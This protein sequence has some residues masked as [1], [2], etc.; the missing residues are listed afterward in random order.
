MQTF[1]TMRNL[2]TFLQCITFLFLFSACQDRV[3]NS[4]P[5]I[6]FCI[7]DDQSWLHTGAMGDPVVK[8]PAFDFIA[9]EGI[10]FTN[11]FCDAPSCGPSRSAI[12]TGQHI[13]RLEE[14]GNIH[15]TLPDKFPTYTDLLENEGYA[16]GSYGKPW[17]PGKFE[18]P[19]NPAGKVFKSFKEFF[20]AKPKDQPFCFWLGSYDAHRAYKL[21]S[22][23]EAGMDPSEVIVPAH[24]P[25]DPLVRNDI[26][27]YYY[28]I[29]R[30]DTTV[31][32]ALKVLEEAGELENTLVVVTSDNGMPFPRAKA[33]IYDFGTHMPMAVS[34]PAR[35]INPDRKYEGFVHL[36]DLAATFLEAAGL[37]VPGEMTAISLMDIFSGSEKTPREAAFTAMERHDGCR[38]GGKAYPCRALRTKDFLYIRNYEPD[39]WPAGN[40]DAKYCA[41]AIPFGEV[42]PSPTK[43]LL[44]ENE[45]EFQEYYDL[46]FGK[47]PAEELFDLNSDPGQINNVAELEAYSG[48]REKLSIR[49][50][51][52]TAKTGDPRALGKDAPWDF[53]PYYGTR[54]NKDWYVDDKPL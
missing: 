51:E 3:S 17:A 34:W 15:S 6:L 19:L 46:A 9:N 32:K 8:T 40:P 38:I 24:L 52:Y 18:S 14:A 53:Y 28:E 31:W 1:F 50:Q 49:L 54:K 48:I 16:I 23:L 42:D 39:R 10:L 20:Q 4:R 33:T 36:S 2:L 22:G 7:S 37:E 44:L 30:W 11:A 12:L 5:N 25:D 45:E 29:Q 27:D 47:R 43:T 26:L 35:I 21:N 13:W 41:R